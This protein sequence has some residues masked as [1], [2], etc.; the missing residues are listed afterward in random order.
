[1]KAYRSPSSK[2]FA[3]AAIICG[4]ML[5]IG[6]IFALAKVENVGLPIGFILS[7][8]ML[9]I[10][11]LCCYL[12]DKSRVLIINTDKISLPRGAQ[13]NGKLVFR[14]TVIKI[15]EIK[16]VEKNLYKGDG[17][18]SQDTYFYTL[19]LTDGKNVTVTLYSFG[20]Q[21]EQEIWDTLKRLS[22]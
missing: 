19:G 2:W 5:L 21:A 13:I 22:L 4:M 20:K 7:G 1:M 6:I 11:F 16:F 15:S 3:I 9:G 8:G 14:K 12:A 17:V 10:L 18:Y